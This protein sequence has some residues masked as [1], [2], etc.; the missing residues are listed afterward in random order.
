MT[1]KYQLTLGTRPLEQMPPEW[2]H[3]F[4]IQVL[5]TC[6]VQKVGSQSLPK[7]GKRRLPRALYEVSEDSRPISYLRRTRSSKESERIHN[8]ALQALKG[9]RHTHADECEPL[10]DVQ[11]S[12]AGVTNKFP[13][14]VWHNPVYTILR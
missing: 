13:Y 1:I 5:C 14:N 11:D 10:I 3:L 12:I 7:L 4:R 2:Y 8:V 6:K 9:C